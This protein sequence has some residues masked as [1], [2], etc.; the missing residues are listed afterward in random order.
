M[1]ELRTYAKRLKADLDDFVGSDSNRLH[2]VTV[3][4]DRDHSAMIEVD[5][6]TDHRAAAEIGVIRADSETAAALR[7]TRTKL[8]REHAQWIY[9][10]RD[11]RV[12]RGRQTYLFKPLHRFHWTESAAMMDASQLIAETIG[13]SAE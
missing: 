8:V 6:T 10:N 4:H 11:L 9:F 12:Y 7:K 3:V 2:Q 13:S 1:P 5:F